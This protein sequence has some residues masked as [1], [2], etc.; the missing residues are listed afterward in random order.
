MPKPSLKVVLQ[1]Q[2]LHA[3]RHQPFHLRRHVSTS[4]M[5]VKAC[6]NMILVTRQVMS[7]CLNYFKWLNIDIS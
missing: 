4:K 5:Q 3:T 1:E 7:M 2:K 6:S